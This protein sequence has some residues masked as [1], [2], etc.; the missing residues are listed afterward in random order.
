ML[1]LVL[2][3]ATSAR[4]QALPTATAKGAFQV[5][6]GFTYAK[7]DYGQ[8]AI[9][10]ASGFADFDFGLHFGVEADIHYIAFVT[11]N[12]LAENTYLAGPRFILPFGRFKLYGKALVGD[13]D[14]VIQEQQDNAGRLSGNFFAY[15][16]GGGL[17]IQ[18][19][20]H[21]VVR[22]ID[23]ESQHWSYQ[24]GLTPTVI[25]V[26]AAYRFR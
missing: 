6:A 24:S 23:L 13:G 15:A 19:T 3:V 4:A 1:A 5:G 14:L 8:G 12:D 20:Q 16:F 7:P 26:G 18:A 9:K 21:I 11:P 25:T 2:S 22:A 17:D 10:G